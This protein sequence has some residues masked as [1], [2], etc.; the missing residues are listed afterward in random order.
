MRLLP[1]HFS[2]ALILENPSPALDD[3]LLQ[4][5]IE[6]ERLP[7]AATQDRALVLRRLAEGQHD[8]IF[9]R[10]RFA[11][12]DAVLDASP[13]LAAIMLCCIGDDSVD[14]TACA[15]RG[16]LVM[17]DPVSN[18]RSV[19]EMV[20]GEIICLARRIFTANDAGRTH[21]WTKSSMRRYEVN[22]KR[23]GL[24]G[25]GHIGKQ[26]ARLGEA[27]GMEIVFYDRAEVAR[28]VGLALG[29]QALGSTAEVFA[30]SDVVTLHVSA[31]DP[32]GKSNENFV[33][34]DDFALLASER[35]ENS[36]R[37]FINASR[38]FLYPVDD[39]KRAIQEGHV[40]AAAVDVFP[41]EPGSTQDAWHNPYADME[42]VVTTPHIGAATQEAQP[43]IATRIAGTTR[44]LNRQGTVRD[45]VYSPRRVIGV[46]ADTPYHVLTVV[47]SDA[48]GTKKAIDDSLYEAGVSNL[49]SNHRDFPAY[50]IAY[51]VNAI[52]APLSDDQIAALVANAQRLSGRDD[53][54]RSLR[55]FSITS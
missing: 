51:D 37:L 22:G 52:D 44:L 10:S 9:K 8:L 23:L 53:A 38:G 46:N 3:L 55:Q 40:R 39:L 26:V 2:K 27:I 6:P 24:I 14:K 35:G 50:G 1:P 47:H 30:Q 4:Q 28:E 5:G 12:D 21:L 36:P 18:G 45:T 15:R 54:I 43:R 41:E 32:G 48:R 31:T 20:L 17:N 49:Q 16:V 29:Y 11:I 7:E 25:L 19:A 42:A 34:F 33:T 13:N